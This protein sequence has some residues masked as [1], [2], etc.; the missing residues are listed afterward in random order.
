M[1]KGITTATF[2][3]DVSKSWFQ[4]HGLDD[5]GQIIQKKLA[6][7]K[8]L[9]FFARLRSCVIGLEACGSAHYWARGIIKL[10]HQARLMPARYVRAYAETSKHAAADAEAC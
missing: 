7:G 2:G 3:L 6:R 10:G 9:G 8:V 4:V 5:D 1:E